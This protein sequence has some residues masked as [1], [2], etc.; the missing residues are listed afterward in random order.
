ME[1]V[2][3]NQ[4]HT[5]CKNCVFSVI[6]ENKQIDCKLNKIKDY[7]NADVE[8]LDLKHSNGNIYKV[9]NGRLCLFYRHPELMEKYPQSNW[10]KI[11]ELQTKVPYQAMLILEKEASFKQLKQSLKKLYD[12]EIKPNLVTLINKQ[13]CSY[14]ESEGRKDFIKPSHILELLKSFNFHQYSLKNVYD[15]TL[16]N[17]DLI[18]ITYDATKEKPYPFY[19]V[20]DTSFDVPKDFSK[21]LNDAI[22]IKM[23]QLGFAKPVDDINGMIVST[24]AHKKHGGNSFNINLEDKILKYEK[25]SNK[26]IFEATDICPSLK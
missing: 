18:D 7:E 24:I 26:F 12:Q 2:E 16:S 25:N 10:E 23:M 13:Y 4:V 15:N 19:I 17:R 8:V 6:K 3:L 9:I 11:V 22:L 20:F 1:S 21:N 14:I 5:C